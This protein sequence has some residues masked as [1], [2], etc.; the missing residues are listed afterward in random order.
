[1]SRLKRFT[2]SL[3]SGY[4][5][6]GVNVLFTLCTV[7]LALH[8]LSEDEYGLWTL[9][10]PLAS[11]ISVLD[12]GL[13]S[14][15][16][17]I[18]ID[19]KDDQASGKYGGVILTDILVGVIQGG[20]VLLVGTALAFVLGP[21][22]K[23]QAN[24]GKTFFWLV[25][26]QVAVFAA[27]FALRIVGHVLMAN[28][29]YDIYNY[30]NAA[31]FGINF[32]ALWWGFS[33]GLGVLSMAL[34]QAAGLLLTVFL[35]LIWCQ[36]LK[37]FPAPGN[38]GRPSWQ[39]F[40]ELFSFGRDTF[41]M[42][43]G[44]Q[45]ITASQP[46]LVTRF[47]GLQAS[48]IWNVCTRVYQLLVQMITRIFNYSA[49]ALA[50]MTVRGETD[51]LLRRFREITILSV[52]LAVAAGTI[53]AICNSPFVQVWMAGK[54]RWP[55][56]NDFLL[57]AWLVVFVAM[58]MH[59]SLIGQTKDFRFMRYIFF[60]EGIVFIGLIILTHRWG[61]FPLMLGLSIVCNLCF[62][63]CYGLHRT[64][65]T[66]N[67][68]WRELA[69]WHESTLRLACSI[70]PVAALIWWLTRSQPAL[71]RLILNGTLSGAWTLF[72]FLRYGLG[73]SIRA[74]LI[75]RAPPWARPIFSGGNPVNK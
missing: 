17:R 25:L 64:R 30:G 53:F 57:A 67:L 43:L 55:V 12:F 65:D 19:Y 27:M 34:G 74:E 15:A 10:T 60:V 54:I 59:T 39:Q 4:A 14:A 73:D 44:Y 1:M 36:K 24:L 31:G 56:W 32:A 71:L 7:R 13:S 9:V 48:T 70:I 72:M 49:A 51:R 28:Q 6:L 45:F 20:I 58:M 33:H 66:F 41:L 38:W 21:L 37:L 47:L 75:R 26:A 8:Y 22:M 42:G 50:E 5:L 16:G 62:S 46:F 61:G 23:V 68:T 63:L 29:R 35:N 2:H 18:L 69:G 52:N 3:L 11:Y 40:H